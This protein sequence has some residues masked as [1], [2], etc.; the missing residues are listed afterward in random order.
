MRAILTQICT[1][2]D[3]VE[4]HLFQ[5]DA[6]TT[7]SEKP[8]INK[9]ARW[10]LQ[11]A[12]NVSTLLNLDLQIDD[13]VSRQLLKLLDGTRN[14][15]N[16]LEELSEFIQTDEQIDDKQDLLNNLESWIEDSIAQLAKLGMFVS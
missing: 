8:E 2:T 6:D 3:L 12:K 15:E 4:L 5:P 7:A 14:K 16:V 11:E 13:E 1:S 9:L 10:Q